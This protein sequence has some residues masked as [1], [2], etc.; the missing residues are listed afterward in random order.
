MEIA[1]C[2]HGH[3]LADR[4]RDSQGWLRCKG[5]NHHRVNAW[6]A[7]NATRNW[8][9]SRR[10]MHAYRRRERFWRAWQAL[11][12]LRDDRREIAT[13]LPAEPSAFRPVFGPYSYQSTSKRLS[14]VPLLRHYQGAEMQQ[15]T[16]DAV[17]VERAFVFPRQETGSETDRIGTKSF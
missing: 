16:T 1:P 13:T 7:N 11:G 6:K 5:C 2:R 17:A 12:E 4:Y 10:A 15:Q 14:A 3:P 9:L 8:I